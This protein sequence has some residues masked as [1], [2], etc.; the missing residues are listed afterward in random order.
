MRQRMNSARYTPFEHRRQFS[1]RRSRHDVRNRMDR[2]FHSI[3]HLMDNAARAL[4]RR[5]IVPAGFHY[6]EALYFGHPD[7]W[8]RCAVAGYRAVLREYIH[9]LRQEWFSPEVA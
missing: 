2:A 8:I 3:Q 9:L 1:L 6:A 7:P 5:R 4:V